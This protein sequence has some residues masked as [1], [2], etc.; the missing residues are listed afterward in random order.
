[1]IKQPSS[2][3]ISVNELTKCDIILKGFDVRIEDYE[4]YKTLLPFEY[5]SLKF[6]YI[7]IYLWL[8]VWLA[9]RFW[10]N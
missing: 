4:L 3:L 5:N 6:Q 7:Y 1:M 2:S 8:K 9:N 10:Y